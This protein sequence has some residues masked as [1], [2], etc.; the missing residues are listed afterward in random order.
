[1]RL[2]R[3]TLCVISIAVAL[4][5]QAVA[6]I[7]D[8]VRVEQG[9]LSGAPG[10]SPDVR[11]YKGVPFAA[12]PVGDMRW[13]PPQPAAP[14]Q[15]VRQAAQFG[16]SCAQT[17][18]PANSVYGGIAP[19]PASEDCLYLNIWTPAKSA[20]DRLPVMVWIH[21]GGFAHS[22]GAAFG[23]DGE[24]L[25]RKGVVVV[26]INYRLGIFGFL[27]LP[28]L[29]AESPHHASGNY[30]LLDQ[31][32]ALEWIHCNIA[33]FGGDSTRVTIFG[34]SAGSAS[35]NV[36]MA[37]P[38][39]KGLFVRAIGE[40]GGSFGP[41]PSLVDAE[42]QGVQFASAL[43]VTQDLLKSLRAKSADDLIKAK[44]N[45]DA[46]PIVDGWV[47][48][49]SV[50]SIFAEGKQNDAPIIVGNNANE[51]GNLAP[52]PDGGIT[53]AQFAENARKNFGSFADQFMKAY[54]AATDDQA[55]AAHFASFRD[56][57]F[58]WDMRIWARMETETGHRRAYRYYFSRVPPGPGSRLGAFHGADLA[59]VFENYPFRI[60]YQDWDKQ[61][62]ETI[63]NYWANF[64]RTG[65]PNG[66]GLSVWPI[67]DPQRDDV[68]EFG[69][70][71]SVQLRVNA[72]GL[73]FFDVYNRSLRS[74]LPTSA[75]SK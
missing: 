1:M 69:D 38:L 20:D 51:G 61:L 45:E 56:A 3:I 14:W 36:L 28:E 29:T 54:P 25:A 57:A 34:Q 62:G 64:A 35:V 16:N 21:G 39:A 31:I 60:F 41:M 55:A 23:Y 49:E 73:D 13:K 63:E 72:A 5:P 10:R 15:G 44:G 40:S 26:T 67:Y 27:A 50:Y 46:E 48:P 7:A 52:L 58:G 4:P 19:P 2:P 32:A 66:P 9:Q 24:N 65:D 53:A 70:Q 43:G 59:Y 8:P 68:L 37:S 18:M 42:K 47:L 6:A 74:P 33:A 12:P 71:I 17:P 75:A 30:A 22:T 11:V